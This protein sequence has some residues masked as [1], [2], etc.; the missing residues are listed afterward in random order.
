MGIT[1]LRGSLRLLPFL[2]KGKDINECGQAG[3]HLAVENVHFNQIPHN[4]CMDHRMHRKS[5]AKKVTQQRTIP[6]LGG[7]ISEIP[8]DQ[9]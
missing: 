2:F 4:D 6:A 3:Q 1:S 7:L 9:G 5:S 8:W